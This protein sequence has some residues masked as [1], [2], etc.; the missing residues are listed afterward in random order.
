MAHARKKLPA[1]PGVGH[2]R[3]RGF[4]GQVDYEILGDPSSLRLGPLRLRGS[5]QTTPEVAADAFREG[6]AVL[7]LESGVTYRL[8][9]IGH[10]AD[11]EAVYFEMRI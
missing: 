8:T 1:F 7:T 3:Y 11:A 9:M 2:L 10:T 4:E 5:L 6:E